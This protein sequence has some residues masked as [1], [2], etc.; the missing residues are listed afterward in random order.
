[1][2]FPWRRTVS[3]GLVMIEGS[4]STQSTTPFDVDLYIRLCLSV[5][6]SVYVQT[7]PFR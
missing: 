2:F 7:R 1:M 3:D 6:L 5:T 4:F